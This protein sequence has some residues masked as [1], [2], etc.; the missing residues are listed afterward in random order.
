MLPVGS[1]PAPVKTEKLELGLGAEAVPLDGVRE[2]V[3]ERPTVT[4]GGGDRE[5][6]MLGGDE[7][8]ASDA[9]SDDG[10]GEGGGGG[11]GRDGT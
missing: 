10:E 5:D 2:V 9:G 11:G 7:G 1:A 6:G 4:G 3:V 8:G